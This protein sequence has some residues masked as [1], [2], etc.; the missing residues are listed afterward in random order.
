MVRKLAEAAAT[1]RRHGAAL[2]ADA[3]EQLG[4]DIGEALRLMAGEAEVLLHA[5]DHHVDAADAF[6]AA[7]V[8]GDAGV[9]RVDAREGA[10]H[11]AQRLA[12]VAAGVG[13]IRRA[14]LAGRG[15][16]RIG[17][18]RGGGIAFGS[19]G[20]RRGARLRLRHGAFDVD[21]RKA[22]GRAAGRGGALG[23]ILRQ[24]MRRVCGDGDDRQGG[25]GEES[26][27]IAP[28]DLLHCDPPR[29]C[30]NGVLF[31]CAG[32]QIFSEEQSLNIFAFM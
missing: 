7:D 22:G 26:G 20:G 2:D 21:G 12:H 8:D 13:D 25:A 23:V 1:G 19:G 3:G 31:A 18:G 10:G 4:I 24:G 16:R 15:G 17:I 29:A 9:L 5:V 6:H 30:E 14:D 11:V 28:D 32:G 27:A